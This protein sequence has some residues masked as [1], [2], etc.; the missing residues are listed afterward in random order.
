MPGL[1]VVLAALARKAVEA[2][3]T[4]E[5]FE[6]PAHPFPNPG[7]YDSRSKLWHRTDTGGFEYKLPHPSASVYAALNLQFSNATCHARVIDAGLELVALVA[8]LPVANLGYFTRQAFAMI[9]GLDNNPKVSRYFGLAAGVR[10]MAGL[11]AIS[12]REVIEIE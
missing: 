4:T 9:R 5:Q 12:A 1:V 2:I 6:T 10:W 7:H 8:G 3:R 11:Y